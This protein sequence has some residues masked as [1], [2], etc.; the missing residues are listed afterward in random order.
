MQGKLTVFFDPPYW[1]GIFEKIE[2]DQIQAA[3]FVFGAEPTDPQLLN[4]ALK[5]YSSL[6]FSQ[7][8]PIGQVDHHPV[9]FKRKM[10]EIRAQME[11]Q[12]R[13]THAQDVLQKEMESRAVERKK[14]SREDRIQVQDRKY[15]LHK[16]RQAEK[17]RGH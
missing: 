6:K 16:A 17:H 9:N 10:R 4:F 8:V 5:E 1:V 14:D 12:P 3:R 2:N 11:T 15:L 13:S 7:P